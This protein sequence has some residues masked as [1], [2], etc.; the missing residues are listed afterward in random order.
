MQLAYFFKA[1]GDNTRLR[2]LNLLI[3]HPSLRVMD[4]VNV[5][6]L[7]QSTVSRHLAILKQAG[8]VV[9][10]RVDVWS[11]YSL[12]PGLPVELK[13]I[14]CQLFQRELVFQ[15]DLQQLQLQESVPSQKF[16]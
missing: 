16:R 7:P 2:I 10:R 1:L 5:L 14:L 6:R 11:H 9:D 4:I 15:D 3:H 13:Q 8:W 12:H